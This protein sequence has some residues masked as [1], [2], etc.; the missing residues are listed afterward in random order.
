MS[1]DSQ[2]QQPRQLLAATEAQFDH[3]Q[4]VESLRKALLLLEQLLDGGTTAEVRLAENL[5]DAYVKRLFAMVENRL[6]D[7]GAISEPN[8]AH[9]FK[10]LITLENGPYALP[11]KAQQTKIEVVRR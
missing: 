8:L 4:A 11:E 3:P 7:P 6:T 10:L 5:G 2:L 9:Y 1:P